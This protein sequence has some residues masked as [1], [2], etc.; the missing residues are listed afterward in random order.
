METKAMHENETWHKYLTK[1][2]QGGHAIKATLAEWTLDYYECEEEVTW[3]DVH[4]HLEMTNCAAGHAPPG[5]IYNC[6]IA[7]KARDWREEIDEAL[8]EWYTNTGERFGPETVGHLVWFA[9]EWF[10][11]EV[12]LGLEGECR[13]EE[14]E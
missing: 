8:E 3:K 9:V 13:E 1:L 6:I 12:A 10:A 5:L 14:E 4:W 7:N 11:R 2:S